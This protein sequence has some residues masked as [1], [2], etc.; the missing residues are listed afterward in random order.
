MSISENSII[1]NN[2]KILIADDSEKNRE[3]SATTVKPEGCDAC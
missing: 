1:K 2:S 3:L